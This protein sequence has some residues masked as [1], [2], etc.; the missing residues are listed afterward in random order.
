VSDFLHLAALAPAGVAACCVVSGGRV[1]RRR[2]RFVEIAV[3]LLML[4]AMID[5]SRRTPLI[6]PV[7]WAAL[8]LVGAL[9]LGA[10]T[11]RGIAGAR[12]DSG[13]RVLAHGPIHGALG[14][15]VMAALVLVMV[16]PAA[17]AGVGAVSHHGGGGP[18]LGAPASVLTV[19]VGAGVLAYGAY[20][21]MALRHGRL[22][23]R[24]Q[25]AAMGASTLGMAAAVFV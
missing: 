21:V 1:D 5:V 6:A 19:M 2:D 11:R 7:L 22:R 20:S 3:T 9:V 12:G 17:G 15:V 13:A 24:I 10:T 16:A 8:L 14:C 25:F 18:L 4:G 23:E